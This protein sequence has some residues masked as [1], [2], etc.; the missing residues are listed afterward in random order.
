MTIRNTGR[1]GWILLTLTHNDSSWKEVRT[2]IWMPV[3]KQRSWRS[4]TYWFA[5]RGLCSPF[6][7]SFQDHMPK[8][9]SASSTLTLPHQSLIT[10]MPSHTCLYRP[11]LIESFSSHM[12]LACAKM[13]HT[14]VHTHTHTH[15]QCVK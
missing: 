12:T 8:D 5:P 15:T 10:T 7:Y 13:E 2:G 9:S 3:L 4:A 6:S 11:I 1:K 14:R